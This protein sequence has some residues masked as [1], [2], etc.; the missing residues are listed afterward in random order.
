MAHIQRLKQA[1]PWAQTPIIINAPMSG[2]ATSDLAVAVTRAGG[3]GQIGFLDNRR[4]LIQ[5]LE[6]ARRQLQDIMNQQRNTPVDSPP[7]RLGN[8]CANEFKVW[9]EGIRETSP[10]TQGWIQ[11]GSVSA[12]LE[13]AQACHPD[14]LVLQGSDAGG[15]GHAYLASIVKLLPEVADTLR[16]HGIGGVS[17]IPTR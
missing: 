6:R 1:L 12:A 7:H 17:L 5:Q 10:H 14:A 4:S 8:D 13:A 9:T 2:A 15:H 16:D 3:L 11:V